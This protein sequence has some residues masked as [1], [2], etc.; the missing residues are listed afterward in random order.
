MLSA[1][2]ISVKPLLVLILLAVGVSAAAEQQPSG[3]GQVELPPTTTSTLVFRPLLAAIFEPRLGF[4]YQPSNERLRLDI[5]YS[6]DVWKSALTSG[7]DGVSKSV[8]AIGVDAFTYSRLRAE[9][10]LKFPVET[11]DYMFG[12][13]GSYRWDGT[14]GSS[15][16]RVRLSHISAHLVDGFADTAGML[17]QR[18]F[19]YSREF[20]DAIVAYQWH[21]PNLRIYGGGTLLLTVKELPLSVGRVI[22]QFGFEWAPPLEV[23]VVAGYDVRILGI[24]RVTKPVHA[25]QL[26]VT[27][28]RRTDA[29]LNVCGY[30]Y[31]GYSMHGMFFDQRDEYWALG[32]QVLF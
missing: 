5:G 1:R 10:N 32:V 6:V 20:I 18:P 23:P 30:Y 27:A 14:R 9:S 17:R 29:T 11:I 13:N 15:A 8:L 7:A 25:V 24:G 4:Q 19:V 2:G 3:Q 12:I 31:A 16:A 21:Q 26:A 28:L 22:P